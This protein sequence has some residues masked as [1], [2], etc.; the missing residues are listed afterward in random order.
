[1]IQKKENK[2]TQNQ[3]RTYLLQTMLNKNQ[4]KIN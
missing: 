2:N 3:I 1:M 4:E